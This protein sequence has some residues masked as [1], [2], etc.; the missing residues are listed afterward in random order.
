MR[1]STIPPVSSS[2]HR[3]Y[4]AL[5]GSIFAREFVSVASTYAEA[6]G[7][8]T[9]ALPRWL[10][11][12]TPTPP[13]TAACSASTPLPAY[14]SGISQPP[15]SANLAPRLTCLS[16][17][18]DRLMPADLP[19]PPSRPGAYHDQLVGPTSAA[20]IPSTLGLTRSPQSHC[21]TGD[22]AARRLRARRRGRGD[23]VSQ[24]PPNI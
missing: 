9:A 4:C 3:V 12:K 6:P 1:S 20:S 18:G 11:S 17:M 22:A 16:C 23:H 14:S 7:P 21:P 24:E 5:P 2:Q 15:N 13:R 19:P 8:R 10:T